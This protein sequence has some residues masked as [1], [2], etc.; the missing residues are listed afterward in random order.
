M[1]ILGTLALALALGACI[2]TIIAGL[3]GGLG[4]DARWAELSQFGV[5]LQAGLI[6]LA[7]A[8]LMYSFLTHDFSLPYVYGR[9][10]TRM[11][12]LYT[13]AS[14][15]GGQEGSL[16]FWVTV[17]G[18]LGA[19]ATWLNRNRLVSMM[20]YFHA[21]LSFTLLGLLFVL[22]FVSSPFDTFA[23]ID[24]PVDGSGLNPL[25]QNPLMV[26]HPPCLLSGFASFSV[27]FAFGMGALLS[28]ETGN[29]WLKATR[30][31]TL[32]SWLFLSVGNILGGMW[33]YRELGWGGYWAWDPVENAA[34]IPWFT[35]SAFLHSVIIQ[36][37][38]G[39]LKR[40]N[41]IL[42]SLTYVLT[43][44]GTWMTRSGLIESVHTFAASEI[45]DFFFVI[46][47]CA[48]ALPTGLIAWR[49]KSL[50]SDRVVESTLSREGAFL[51]NNWMLVGMAFVVLWGTLF[52]KIKEMLTGEQVSIGPT[53]YNDFLTPLG[54]GLMAMIGLGTLLPWRRTTWASIRRNFTVP[55]GITLV[56][57]PLMM[58]G[59]YFFRMQPLGVEPFSY[60]I[61]MAILAF[62]LVVFNMSTLITEFVTGTR[63]RLKV[64]KSVPAAF[65]SL[66]SRHRRRYGGYVVHI[67]FVMIFLAFIGNALKVDLDA[68][69]LPGQTV[70]LG[71]YEVRYDGLEVIDRIDRRETWATVSLSRNGNDAGV[72]RPSRFDFNDYSMLMGGR[73]D[74][75][76]VTSEIY[77]RSTPVEDVYI[78]LLNWDAETNAAAFKLVILPFTWWF[79]FG[80]LVLIAGTLV[81]MWPDPEPGVRRTLV[82]RASSAAEGAGLVGV[83]VVT[84]LVLLQPMQAWAQEIP[85]DA[86]ASVMT[87]QQR[88]EANEAYHA[89]MTT[90]EGCAGK[91][92]AT[93]SPSCYPSNQDKTRIQQMLMQGNTLQQVLD[94]FVEE[95]GPS[96]LAVPPAE[97]LNN[98]AWIMPV[99]LV[100]GGMVVV[101][102]ASRSMMGKRLAEPDAVATNAAPSGSDDPYLDA[103]HAE[104]RT[105]E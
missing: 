21:V 76:K 7:S 42:V 2:F 59:Y 88:H 78:A 86:H 73:A 89:L 28:G 58:V 46:L 68:T 6:W 92:L 33:A 3:R 96:A 22:N 26:I 24:T 103:L 8:S 71:D 15:W 101:G 4:R 53:W 27:P 70:E 75:M 65:A 62:T 35:A 83:L 43:I 57:A 63:A 64:E 104:L 25:L 40:W 30:R 16:L 11:P 55:T 54:I 13:L 47:I 56:L 60:G 69:L 98:L 23:V 74:P 18:G 85:T 31:W 79:W 91:T 39:M 36:E 9:S 51:L 84:A 77:I 100:A 1:P 87:D 32:L 66:F 97:G 81:C 93:A 67:G 95:R 90:C 105:R 44:L 10:D 41:A 99:V 52:P 37:Q 61:A 19:A 45:G 50:K 20:P 48:I 94:T 5:Y 72:L 12:I 34:L 80:G 38:R 49:W 14:F 82:R 29:D 17:S 102:F